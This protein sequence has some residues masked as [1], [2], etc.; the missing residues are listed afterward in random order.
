MLAE[1]SQDT[2]SAL[3]NL[4]T[5]T[6]SDR[7]AVAQL[8]A[9]VAALK[10]QIAETQAK[11]TTANA[12]ITRLKL[13]AP[14]Q[15]GGTGG[16]DDAANREKRKAARIAKQQAK[17]WKKGGYCHSHGFKVEEGHDLNTCRK[18]TAAH[19]VNV[20]RADPMGG[21]QWNKGWDE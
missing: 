19:N 12:E 1:M 17:V 8:T 16:G 2:A 21:S 13:A 9:T 11:L 14:Y 10:I 20:T 3:A 18:R 6:Q 4:A 5:A 15:T 7:T